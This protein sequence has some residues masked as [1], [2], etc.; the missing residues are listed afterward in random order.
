[1]ILLEKLRF[2]IRDPQRA[3]EIGRRGS[4]ISEMRGNHTDFVAGW[5][6][7]FTRLLSKNQS[8]FDLAVQN[9][10]RLVSAVHLRRFAP[11]IRSL[12]E[13]RHADLIQEFSTGRSGTDPVAAGIEFC[14]FAQKR[15]GSNGLEHRMSALLD[16]IRYQESRL[17]TANH[18]AGGDAPVFAVVDQLNGRTVSEEYPGNLWPVHSESLD[19]R[20]FDF[21]VTP[22][23]Y[24]GR[25][26]S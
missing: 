10:S 8:D 7:L 9:E 26:I 3:R 25:S 6:Q 24:P 2:I 23:F 22:L 21:D 16:A 17:Q 13:T 4:L 14:A 20:A 5:E 1:M 11:K 18:C 12:V 19:I 15:L